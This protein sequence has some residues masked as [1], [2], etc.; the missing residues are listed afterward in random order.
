[1]SHVAD[2][3]LPLWLLDHTIL[4]IVHDFESS[5]SQFSSAFILLDRNLVGL[6][7][8]VEGLH[9]TDDCGCT[10]TE[11]LVHTALFSR[12]N[13]FLDFEVSH[14]HFELLQVSH[15]LY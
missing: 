13:H 1:M 8:V 10:C 3:N 4:Q 6:S 12:F 15:Q 2:W 5:L 7:T 9:W 11:G 14:C